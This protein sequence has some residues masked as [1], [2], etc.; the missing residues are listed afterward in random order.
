MSDVKPFNFGSL[1]K[2]SRDSVILLDQLTVFLP[3]IG[4]SDELGRAVKRI[5]HRLLGVPFSFEIEKIKNESLNTLKNSL[6]RQGVYLVFGLAP[7]QEKGWLEID[8]FM[9]QVAI[10]R[11]LGGSGEPLTMV[12]PLTEIEEGVLSYIFL[13]ILAEI[14]ERS[15]RSARVHFRLEGCA[16]SAD[17]L[18]EGD[19][20]F[21]TLRLTLGNRSG[22]ARMILP[23]PF[24]RKALLDPVEGAVLSGRE[25][26]YYA[27]RL[28]NLGFLE[29][30]LW[31]EIGRATLRPK[32]LQ[33]L[34]AGDVFVLEKT[35]VNFRG[36]RL[37][38]R[39]PLRVGR[40]ECGSFSGQV[41]SGEGPL[42]LK[43]E[44][45]NLEHPV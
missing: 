36:G 13:K 2:V 31:A 7:L 14:F 5:V 40:G 21:I 34:E 43:V 16:A 15:G 28:A 44:G 20:I 38:G 3:R 11:L 39:M 26:E 23:S 6:P 45:M 17:D 18:A 4:F 25:L 37:D 32:D 27:A 35:A 33:G 41:V 12:R 42:R 30:D 8:P 9:A 1:P 29:T 24:V 22:Y 19:G 10:D